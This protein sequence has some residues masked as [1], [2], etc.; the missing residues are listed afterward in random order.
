[1]RL[2]A[3]SIPDLTRD[4]I[5]FLNYCAALGADWLSLD[6]G[7]ETKPASAMGYAN[8]MGVSSWAACGIPIVAK[9][10]SRRLRAAQD[11]LLLRRIGVPDSVDK[12]IRLDQLEHVFACPFALLS[13]D[14][15]GVA[16][17]RP[18]RMQFVPAITDFAEKIMPGSGSGIAQLR[19]SDLRDARAMRDFEGTRGD[20]FSVQSVLDHDGI[21]VTMRY[22]N[23]RSHVEAMFWRFAAVTGVALEEV[24]RG[25]GI[26]PETLLVLGGIVLPR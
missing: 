15:I 12:R 7:N 13:S 6:R 3:N 24:E 25:N 20:V 2:S 21:G 1:M 16:R 17:P 5:G 23:Q 19:F 18:W 11:L 9:T 4:L 26:E 10:I 14:G 22:L 8:A